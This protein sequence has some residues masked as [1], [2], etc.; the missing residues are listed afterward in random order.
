VLAV[1]ASRLTGMS[2]L[3]EYL[4][5]PVLGI[6]SP[7]RAVR[8]SVGLPQIQ[9]RH[10]VTFGILSGPFDVLAL[11]RFAMDPLLQYDACR[12]YICRPE[13][14]GVSSLYEFSAYYTGASSELFCAELVKRLKSIER[15]YPVQTPPSWSSEC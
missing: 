7:Y 9:V 15:T 11:L 12:W 14:A 5:V 2:R 13:A 3:I 1:E 6:L 8:I 4:A 10:L